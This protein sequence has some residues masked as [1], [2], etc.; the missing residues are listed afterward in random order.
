LVLPILGGVA[1][2]RTISRRLISFF[3]R[4]P[5]LSHQKLAVEP[6]VALDTKTKMT[7]MTTT[8]RTSG[9]C[10]QNVEPSDLQPHAIARDA[11]RKRTHMKERADLDVLHLPE[12]RCQT[13][14][15]K[16]LKKNDMSLLDMVLLPATPPSMGSTNHPLHDRG[17]V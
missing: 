12:L 5:P 6:P 2:S 10:D 8:R 15:R 9:P 14:V 1:G 17:M 13:A 4:L 7:R 3:P 16:H 11:E